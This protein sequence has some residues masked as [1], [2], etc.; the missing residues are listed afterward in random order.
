MACTA[1]PHRLK[2]SQAEHHRA[3]SVIISQDTFDDQQIQG[4]SRNSHAEQLARFL[5]CSPL[6]IGESDYDR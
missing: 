5:K 2:Y 4:R 3:M 1:V 6:R